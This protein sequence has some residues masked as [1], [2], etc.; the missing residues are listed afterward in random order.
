PLPTS[1]GSFMRRDSAFDVPERLGPFAPGTYVYRQVV[2]P[3]PN[4]PHG[5]MTTVIYPAIGGEAAALLSTEGDL[6]Q[7]IESIR[8]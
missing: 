5:I 6:L 7:T 1:R 2:V 8:F 3:N 4:G